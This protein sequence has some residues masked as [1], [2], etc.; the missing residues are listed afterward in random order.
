MSG[1]G[2]NLCRS[3]SDC[4]PNQLCATT[5]NTKDLTCQGDLSCYNM[6]TPFTCSP[7]NYNANYCC[8]DERVVFLNYYPS[9]GPQKQLYYC[10]K[11][12]ITQCMQSTSNSGI[13]SSKCANRDKV[14]SC[15]SQKNKENR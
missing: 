12:I 3:N 15:H 2:F 10:E 9:L 8:P 4:K 14:S 11:S 1:P 6:T 13:Q 5:L 7:E